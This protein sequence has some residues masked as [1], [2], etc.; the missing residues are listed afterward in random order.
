M[1]RLDI[2]NCQLLNRIKSLK[3]GCFGHIKRY[4]SIKKNYPRS[5]SKKNMGAKCMGL[6]GDNIVEVD[7]ASWF[8]RTMDRTVYREIVRAA[9]SHAE[10]KKGVL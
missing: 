8:E 7:L 1:R 5:R 3:L 4:D 2:T 9:T 6:V 10:L